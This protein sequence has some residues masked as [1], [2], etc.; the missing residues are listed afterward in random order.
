MGSQLGNTKRSSH[1]PKS[2]SHM[3]V[4][5]KTYCDLGSVKIKIPNMDIRKIKPMTFTILVTIVLFIAI[6]SVFSVLAFTIGESEDYDNGGI[7]DYDYDDEEDNTGRRVL[8]G[9]FLST[10]GILGI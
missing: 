6:A 8:C 5:Q 3:L 2:N 9:V 7:F 10:F 4:K 1:T